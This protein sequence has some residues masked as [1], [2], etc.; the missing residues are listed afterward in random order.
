MIGAVVACETRLRRRRATRNHDGTAGLGELHGRDAD[1]SG[2]AGDQN[3]LAGLHLAAGEQGERIGRHRLPLLRGQQLLFED[4]GG[5][6]GFVMTAF[7]GL[8]GGGDDR[9]RQR[10]VVFQAVGQ[11]VAIHHPFAL[12]IQRQDRGAGGACKIAAHH[13]F[14]RQNGQALADHHVRVRVGED[15]VGADI[16]G[17]IEPEACGLGQHLTLP[18]DAGKDAVE[19]R[20]SVRRDDD[21]ASV[22]QVV[23]V[24]HLAI[25]GVGKLWDDG[26]IE[27][28]HG[29]GP[30]R[31]GCDVYRARAGDM[32]T[33]VGRDPRA[34]GD[35]GAGRGP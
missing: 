2:R 14:D 8:A 9:G 29:L 1:S 25:V 4:L 35:G 34:A 28:A 18:R 16:G 24:A 19:G 33:G 12:L 7:K 11:G 22:R 3:G 10:C 17:G 20:D 21:T 26:V 32:S 31:M 23:I 13:D 5:A 27:D 6:E 30:F 15:V